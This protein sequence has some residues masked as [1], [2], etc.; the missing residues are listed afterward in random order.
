MLNEFVEFLERT[1]YS[2]QTPSGNPSTITDYKNRIKKILEKESISIY[3]L[4]TDID[5]Y[6][7]KYDTCG[8]EE[9]FGKKSH[10]AFIS[11]LKKF[12][13]FKDINNYY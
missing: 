11:A 10:R 5:R 12:Q 13:E 1:G 7:Q 9:E 4:Y 2:K 3:Q 6:V 8:E